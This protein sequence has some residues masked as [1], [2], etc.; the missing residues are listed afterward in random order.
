MRLAS[1][2]TVR[3]ARASFLFPQADRSVR[4]HW[5]LSGACRRLGRRASRWGGGVQGGVRGCKGMRVQGR[6]GARCGDGNALA[7]PTRRPPPRLPPQRTAYSMSPPRMS[8]PTHRAHAP[9]TLTSPLSVSSLQNART[10]PRG[11]SPNPPGRVRSRAV[12]AARRALL[13]VFRVLRCRRDGALAV[14]P[15]CFPPPLCACRRPEKTAR[16]AVLP[17]RC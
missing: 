8:V 5:A 13:V 1:R 6:E 9:L 7:L 11:A 2:F 16:D 17:G 10:P 3:R 4:G 14:R 12:S 15:A